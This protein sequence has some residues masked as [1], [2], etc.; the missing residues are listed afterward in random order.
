MHTTTSTTTTPKMTLNP[1]LYGNSLILN[2][3]QFHSTVGKPQQ[4]FYLDDTKKYIMIK[5][6]KYD[7]ATE[8]DENL[9]DQKDL[10]E[11]T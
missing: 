5:Q 2:S 11:D 1:H 8:M 7:D 3:N 6:E 9:V 4:A 10:M